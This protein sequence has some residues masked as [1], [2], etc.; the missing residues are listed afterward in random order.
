M[1]VYELGIRWKLFGFWFRKLFLSGHR[2]EVSVPPYVRICPEE[3]ISRKFLL[4]I[5]GRFFLTVV[6]QGTDC[7]FTIIACSR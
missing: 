3:E 4:D 6:D 7:P 1:V 5:E 2:L